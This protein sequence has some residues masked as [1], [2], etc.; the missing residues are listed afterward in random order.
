[1]ILNSTVAI[2]MVAPYWA[3]LRPLCLASNS[4]TNQLRAEL[5][6]LHSE[7]ERTRVKANSARLRLLRLSEAAEKLRRQAAISM[8]TGKE[9]DAREALFQKKKVMLALEKS[10]SRI[11]L[12]DELSTKLNEAISLKEN[13]L[14]GSV[15]VDLEDVEE[16]A[17]KPVRIISLKQENTDLNEIKEFEHSALEFGVRKDLQLSSQSQEI[18]PVD[19]D[20]EDL[21]ASSSVGISKDDIMAGLSGVSSYKDFLEHL[22]RELGSIEAELLT[23]LRVST[24]VLDDN[25]TTNN[26][27]VQ[28]TR[29]LLQDIRGI[30]KRIGCIQLTKVETA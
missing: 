25:D 15:A 27:K 18:L 4:K 12:L 11:E 2:A 3:P 26:L 19:D 21:Q 10:K 22:D 14:V 6:Q 7:A 17:S 5:D 16:I 13:K 1:M 29:E 20:P 23:I 30:R 28:Q 9:N 8:Q 24:L